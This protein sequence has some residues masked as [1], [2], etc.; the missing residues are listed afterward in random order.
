MRHYM[1]VG[2]QPTK[3]HW[4]TALFCC[5]LLG[6]SLLPRDAAAQGFLSV[7]E[8]N[9]TLDSLEH[10]AL[11]SGTS[12]GRRSA[13]IALAAAG[14]N[15]GQDPQSGPPPY[16]GIVPRLSRIYEQSGDETVQWAILGAMIQQ[17]DRQGAA[18]FL[19]DVATRPDSQEDSRYLQFPLQ[20]TA[21]WALSHLG[22]EGR[23]EL[24]R[25]HSQGTV[26]NGMARARLE[27]LANH[28]FG[29]W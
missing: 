13:A 17:S 19:A 12:D 9:K 22:P 5:L 21:I 24:Q 3:A 16:P 14:W 8:M 15:V 10:A 29:P 23:V 27:R 25:L 7:A 11:S 28:G 4:I 18:S 1:E 6:A 2:P 26:R 20:Y